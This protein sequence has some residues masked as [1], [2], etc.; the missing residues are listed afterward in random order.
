MQ[1]IARLA[2]ITLAALKLSI[3]LM[4]KLVLFLFLLAS[5]PLS[6]SEL[7]DL[8]MASY[9]GKSHLE[10]FLLPTD[11]EHQNAQKLFF[12]TL[13][14]EKTA[15]LAKKWATL[16]FHLK[17]VQH[18][19][20]RFLVLFEADEHRNGRGFYL[21]N[22]ESKN[23]LILTSPHRNYDRYTGHIAYLLFVK[24]DF[25]CAA[26][27]TFPRYPNGRIQTSGQDLA[28][29]N[30]T[31]FTALTLVFAKV[32][33]QGSFVQLHGFSQAKRKTVVA[34]NADLIL[35][36]GNS[37]HSKYF[38]QLAGRLKRDISEN[39]RI[40]PEETKALGGTTNVS[41]QILAANGH[42]G[43]IHVEMSL[44]LREQL[45]EGTEIFS[46]FLEAFQ[47]SKK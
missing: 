35:S 41:G 21:F 30:G 47:E 16:N 9:S 36:S 6:A 29:Q 14:G 23:P 3:V 24:G 1:S 15:I 34:Q 11:K 12:H 10:H 8:Y 7:D 38:L 4:N 13:R 45:K 32:L 37:S 31:Y 33:P 22:P 39:V 40:Y 44:G 43:F 42:Q 27:N 2:S 20:R 26:W 5:I 46:K 28:H 17:E 18:G 25:L 19:K